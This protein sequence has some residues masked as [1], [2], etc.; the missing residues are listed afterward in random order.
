MLLLF[1]G[2]DIHSERQAKEKLEERIIKYKI[3]APG[4]K[5]FPAV[6]EPRVRQ[7][8]SRPHPNSPIYK[9]TKQLY[10][11]SDFTQ[12]K[13]I[14]SAQEMTSSAKTKIN[15]PVAKIRVICEHY[16]DSRLPILLVNPHNNSVSSI[17]AFSKTT[18]SK[19]PLGEECWS[20]PSKKI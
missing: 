7:E 19:F 10:P 14:R 12:V 15:V 4:I 9:N 16:E 3:S 1:S 18:F 20:A 13:F 8:T 5:G 17:D 6:T 11:E 2:S